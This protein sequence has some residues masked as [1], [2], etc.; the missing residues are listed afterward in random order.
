MGLRGREGGGK[1]VVFNSS[2]REGGKTG[3]TAGV[4]AF[5]AA[6][7]GEKAG[8]GPDGILSF[9]QVKGG[10]KAKKEVAVT[11]PF[12]SYLSAKKKGGKKGT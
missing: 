2:M 6:G 5:S 4:S 1:T 8:K 10:E 11:F 9:C 12:F 7:E 3:G